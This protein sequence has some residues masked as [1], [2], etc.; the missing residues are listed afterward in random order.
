MRVLYPASAYTAL[1]LQQSWDTGF[2]GRY[3]RV[4]RASRLWSQGNR[5]V[6]RQGNTPEAQST[7]DLGQAFVVRAAG[8]QMTRYVGGGDEPLNPT[9]SAHSCVCAGADGCFAAMAATDSS[10]SLTG[11][12]GDASR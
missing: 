12:N 3:G 11:A 7:K 6:G 10:S 1:T 5:R 2:H 9:L 4:R 8:R